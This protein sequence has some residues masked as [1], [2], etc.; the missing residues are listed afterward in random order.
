MLQ[1]LL[2]NNFEWIKDTSKFNED[3]IKNYNE[4]S[5]ER[6]FLE[7]DV[8]YPEILQKLHNDLLLLLERMK[9]KKVK[10]FLANLDEKFEYVMHIK[11]WKQGLNHGLV[12][13][14]VQ[15]VIEFNQNVLLNPY[16]DKN[17][18]LSKNT[19]NHFDK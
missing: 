6:F 8:E 10:K 17:T 15:R 12:L 13:K 1:M 14:K 7:I 9:I 2:V 5:D 19:K 11:N 3:F 18:G 4:E 16:T